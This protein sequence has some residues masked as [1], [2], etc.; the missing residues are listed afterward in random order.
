MKPTIPENEAERLNALRR[1]QILDTPPEPAF[2]RIAE[3]AANLFQVPMAGV[4]LVDEDRVWFKSRVGIDAHQTARDAGLC[5]TAMLSEGVFHL[6]DATHDE[7]ATAHS[8]VHDLGIR[9]Y[10]GAP[11]RT[12]Q[13]LNLGTVWVID[14]KPRELASGE[15]ETLRFL[16]AL[17]MNQMELRLYAEKVVRLEQAE[18][19]VGEQLRHRSPTL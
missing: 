11:L 14:Q 4:S 13:G 1:Y 12:E 19:T 16:A 9:F 3:M 10:A 7:R 2:D 5:S 17:A 18:R 8:L 6:R 15:E